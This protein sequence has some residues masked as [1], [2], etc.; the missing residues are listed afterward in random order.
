M[1]KWFT[2]A[3][4]EYEDESIA[5]N[6]DHVVNVYDRTVTVSKDEGNEEVTTTYIF[7][8]PSGTWQVK[9]SIEVV[10]ARLNER[11]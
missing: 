11:D 2:N 4:K 7:C 10:V 1:L 3:T 6:S 5:I 9:E 8:G